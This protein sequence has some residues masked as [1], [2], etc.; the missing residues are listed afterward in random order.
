MGKESL[1]GRK[2]MATKVS[3]SM[4]Q[5]WRKKQIFFHKSMIQHRKANMILSTK[6]YNGT[7]ITSHEDISIEHNS[8]FGEL[9]QEPNENNS[10][11]IQ[12][13]VQ[14]IP[15]VL[16]NDHNCNNPWLIFHVRKYNPKVIGHV[17]QV[18]WWV[19]HPSGCSFRL[20]NGYGNWQRQ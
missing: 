4:A 15:K 11:A 5:V 8:F 18:E 7:M 3:N 9:L 13:I 1:E 14:N 2:T 20:I 10:E 19:K 6:K 17:F 16:N 12:K